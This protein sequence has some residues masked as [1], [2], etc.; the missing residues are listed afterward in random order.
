MFNVITPEIPTEAVILALGFRLTAR[1]AEPDVAAPDTTG[2]VYD[3]EKSEF[4]LT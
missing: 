3:D 1:S 2:A 4:A